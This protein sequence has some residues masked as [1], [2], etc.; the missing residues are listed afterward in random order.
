MKRGGLRFPMAFAA[1]VSLGT[2]A[3]GACTAVPGG[4]VVLE[5]AAVDPEV[6]LWD[7]R[8]RLVDYAAGSWGSTRAVLAH[9][10]LAEPGTQALVVTCVPA[11]AHPKFAPGDADAI[12]V[13]VVSGPYRGRYGWVLSSDL[14]QSRPA[15]ESATLSDPRN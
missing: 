7:S 1:L 12:G 6:F 13:K 5:S 11:A 8:V 3:A 15:G 14:R 9:T 4:R 10:M 2:A